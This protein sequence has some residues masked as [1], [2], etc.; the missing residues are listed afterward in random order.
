MPKVLHYNIFY[1]LNSVHPRY[2]KCLF[3]NIHK[4]QNK[5]K[6]YFLRKI[7]TSQVNNSRIRR[8]K[9]AKFSRY[10]FYINPNIVKFSNP[11]QCT[12][13]PI[14]RCQN[15]IKATIHYLP[16][17]PNCLDERRTLLENA[18]NME[19]H[20]TIKM[21]SKYQKCFYLVSLQIIMHQT[22]VF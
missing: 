1:F 3:T 7:Q 18:Q 9:N 12:F 13:N 21:M 5:L 17:C 11:H 4:Q 22:H 8:I 6:S 19:K 10:H 14:C 16:H 2:M 15:D 20:F